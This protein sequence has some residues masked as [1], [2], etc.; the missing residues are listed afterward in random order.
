MTTR[1]ENEIDLLRKIE[2]AYMEIAAGPIIRQL[3]TDDARPLPDVVPPQPKWIKF[4]WPRS[5]EVNLVNY[6]RQVDRR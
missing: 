3:L 6:W 2:L 4:D 1:L 5:N